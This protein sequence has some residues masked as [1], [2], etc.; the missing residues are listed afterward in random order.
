MVLVKYL[1]WFEIGFSKI[2]FWILNNKNFKNLL[3]Q[4]LPAIQYYTDDP[5][6]YYEPLPYFTISNDLN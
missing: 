5:Y 1:K 6:S 2:F 4:K 3:P